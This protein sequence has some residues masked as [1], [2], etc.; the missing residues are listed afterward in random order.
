MDEQIKV[1][2]KKT[3]HL[4]TDQTLFYFFQFGKM[5]KVE[6]L[7]GRV[8]KLLSKA[9]QEVLEVVRETV[10]EY[11]EKTARTQ[12][13]NQSLKR[14]LQE[15]QDMINSES[16]GKTLHLFVCI[17]NRSFVSSVAHRNCCVAGMLPQ[18]SDSSRQTERQI[19]ERE[20]LGEDIKVIP[21]DKDI[22][23]ISPSDQFKDLAVSIK[24]LAMPCVS[25]KGATR[26][27]DSLHS[28][29]NLKSETDG[30]LSLNHVGSIVVLPVPDYDHKIKEPTSDEDG[31]HIVDCF[32]N[33]A[34][35]GLNLEPLQA[36][37]GLHSESRVVFS[38]NHNGTDEPRSQRYETNDVRADNLSTTQF[39]SS[40]RK[41]YSC[42][43]CGRTF[44]HASNYKKHSRTHTGEKPYCCPVCGKSF[45]QSGYLTVHLRYHT[46]EKPFSCS[47]C[48]KSFAHSSNMKQH[49]QTHR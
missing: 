42:S 8:E 37:S 20:N 15:L 23:L 26:P 28:V 43:V 27:H 16:N 25:S 49:E 4:H 40:V 13:E 41:Q 12:R 34:S 18:M 35:D 19:N 24:S 3:K 14:R 45:S 2:K 31:L 30:G 47:Y 36:S 48:G 32:Y 11:Q 10:L 9:V 6:R 39:Q 46:G 17:D 22:A 33:S 38:L 44:A 7:N 1:K 29:G 21:T 5:S